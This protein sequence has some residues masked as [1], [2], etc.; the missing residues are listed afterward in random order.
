MKSIS[1]ISLATSLLSTLVSAQY[2][3][4]PN[5]VSE[6]TRDGWCQQQ[7]A[8]C[9]LICLQTAAN[10]ATTSSNECDPDSLTYSCVCDNGISP[11]VSE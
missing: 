7:T 8:Q 3:I 4:D 5:S 2:A 6:S 9:P 10:S 1:Q 11:N